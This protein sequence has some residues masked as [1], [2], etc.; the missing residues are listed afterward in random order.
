MNRSLSLVLAGQSS[1]RSVVAAAIQ[2]LLQHERPNQTL[3]G[4][5]PAEEVLN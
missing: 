5:T 4:R 3:D 2:I 1:Q